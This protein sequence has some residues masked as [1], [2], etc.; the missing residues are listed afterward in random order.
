MKKLVSNYYMNFLEGFTAKISPRK[1]FIGNEYDVPGQLDDGLSCG[2]VGAPQEDRP[3]GP[4]AGWDQPI[5]VQHVETPS[6][7]FWQHMYEYV[8]N[9]TLSP[10]FCEGAH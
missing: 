1:G 2:G 7:D 9:P 10:G 5:Q 8:E 3:Q 4:A 6:S